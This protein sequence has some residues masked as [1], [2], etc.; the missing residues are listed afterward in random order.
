[1]MVYDIQ[2]YWVFGIPD[3]GQSPQ[4]PIVLNVKD[5]VFDMWR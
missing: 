5:A 4:N 3:D 1:M 2:D